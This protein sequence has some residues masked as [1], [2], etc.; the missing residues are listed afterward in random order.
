MAT[1]YQDA[2]ELGQAK[3]AEIENLMARINTELDKYRSLEWWHYGHAGDVT[4]VERQLG[5]LWEFVA[6]AQ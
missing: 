6:E 2:R 5:E 4:E 1:G 3:L